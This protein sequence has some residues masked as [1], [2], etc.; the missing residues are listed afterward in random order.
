ME[1]IGAGIFGWLLKLLGLVARSMVWLVFAAW[2]YLIVNLAW[3]FG[4]PICRL[5]SIGQFPK[6]E[7]GNG[8][9]ASLTEAVSVCLV[10][11]AVPCTMAVLLAPWENF[12]AS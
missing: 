12:G 10:G 1:E 4:W 6:A 2:E 3:Y 11:L 5:L 9:N 8:D 7:I